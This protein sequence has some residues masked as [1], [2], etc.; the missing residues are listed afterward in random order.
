MA[1]TVKRIE[2]LKQQGRYLDGHGLVL[3]V[4]PNRNKSWLFRYG[5]NGRER[6]MGLGPLHTITLAEARER[7]RKARQLLLDGIDPLE[8][9][10]A[11]RAAQALA[12]AKTLTFKQAAEKYFDAH[13]KKW[14][15][16]K[17][18]NSFLSSL[19]T[20]AYK[21]IGALAVADIDT[22]AVLRCIEPI[23][24]TKTFTANHLRSRIEAVLG[25]AQ[26]RGYR[27]G[28]NPARWVGHLK[29][30]L[31]ATSEVHKPGHLPALP[32]KELPAFMEQLRAR[33]GVGARGL[34]FTI[35]TAT[36]TGES[37]R[38]RRDE[39]DLEQK[40]WVIPAER[41][42]MDKEHRVPLSSAA[43][44]L[45]EALP[46]E[47]GNPFVFI[48]ASKG[49]AIS[50]M[51]LWRELQRMGRKDLT[52]HGFRSTFRD[53]AA[54]RTNYPHEVCEQAL[55]HSI[56]SAVE[57]AYRRGDLFDKRRRLME[58]WARYCGAALP[59]RTSGKVVALRHG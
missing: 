30:A 3:Q 36:R 39:I 28:D 44:Q 11:Q 10:R 33:E 20:Y 53:W 14:S 22:A 27:S 54:E 7:A 9:K 21:Y 13:Q 29:E 35:L 40:V 51:V 8:A 18:R 2:R 4:G 52:V 1:L 31:P 24:H 50:G 23:W 58:E 32:Y 5:R 49:S 15:S 59:T 48:G 38:A 47:R 41:M 57:K 34:E 42:K 46:R 56:G 55:A 17:A 26:V 25:W 12:E 37:H 43:I 16:R 45:L 19:Q 6:F